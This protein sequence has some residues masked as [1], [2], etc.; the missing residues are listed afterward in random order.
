MKLCEHSWIPNTVTPVCICNKSFE[1]SR[2]ETYMH[3]I[4]SLTK[5]LLLTHFLGLLLAILMALISFA[6]FNLDYTN[7]QVLDMGKTGN[8]SIVEPMYL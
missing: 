4:T 5:R 6:N 2:F 3:S 7:W 8:F 1:C